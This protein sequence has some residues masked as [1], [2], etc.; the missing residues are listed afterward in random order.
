MV[1][2]KMVTARK[3]KKEYQIYQNSLKKVCKNIIKKTDRKILEAARKGEK[4]I[5]SYRFLSY[6]DDI[7]SYYIDDTDL[8][9]I[10]SQNTT[11]Q[12][13]ESYYKV[14]GF[15]VEI[16]KNKEIYWLKIIWVED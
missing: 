8:P 10:L 14:K 15:K 7:V 4:Y 12:F 9:Q 5:Y 11:I 6:K 2:K 1:S 13:F 16:L 3:A